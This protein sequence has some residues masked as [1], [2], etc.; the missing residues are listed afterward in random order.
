MAYSKVECP[1]LG[2]RHESLS[3]HRRKNRN[4]FNRIFKI[5]TVDYFLKLDLLSVY[6]SSVFSRNIHNASLN[7]EEIRSSVMASKNKKIYQHVGSY[8]PKIGA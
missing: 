7:T 8:S 5:E 6:S 3:K 4:R 2:Q 1:H